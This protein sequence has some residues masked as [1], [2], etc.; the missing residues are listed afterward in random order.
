MPDRPRMIRFTRHARARMRQRRI[1]EDAVA[2]T[3]AA[4]MLSYPAPVRGRSPAC[5]V[6]EG[7][8]EGR[9]YKVYVQDGTDPP[10][11]ATVAVRGE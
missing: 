1:S 2:A 6:C 9:R 7:Q 4:P 11:V 10:V 3:L 8:I 5:T